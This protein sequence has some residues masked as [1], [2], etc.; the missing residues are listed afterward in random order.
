MNFFNRKTQKIVTAVIAGIIVL[1]M[2]L[3][4]FASYI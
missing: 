1:S 4:M 3:S 2:V